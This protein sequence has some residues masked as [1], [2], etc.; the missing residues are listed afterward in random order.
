MLTEFET[1]HDL[2]ERDGRIT[3]RLAAAAL[4]VAEVA[5]D[6]QV[7]EQNRLLEGEPDAP[8]VRRHE[9]AAAVVLPGGRPEG[10]PSGK[11]G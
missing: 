4:G 3:F 7:T 1:F 6:R 2:D 9:D 8:A 11:G 5:L 10:E